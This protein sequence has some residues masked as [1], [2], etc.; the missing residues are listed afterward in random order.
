[1]SFSLVVFPLL[2]HI[3]YSFSLF[4]P[5]LIARYSFLYIQIIHQNFT[6]TFMH[7]HTHQPHAIESFFCRA[8]VYSSYCSLFFSFS[9]V[10]WLSLPTSHSWSLSLSL[11]NMLDSTVCSFDVIVHIFLYSI[12]LPPFFCCVRARCLERI[13]IHYRIAFI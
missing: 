9:L 10:F 3:L 2:L 1:M 6:I 8:C 7:T 13:Y 4:S 11:R 5:C 12:S